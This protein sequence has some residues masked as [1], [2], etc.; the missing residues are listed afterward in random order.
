[1]AKSR[2]Y[3][4]YQR[5]IIGRYYDNREQIDSQ[6][7]AEL[8]TNLY[9]S[10]GKKRQKL[11]TTAA[12][13]MRRLKVPESRIGHVVETNDPAILA[14]VVNDLQAGRIGG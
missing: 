8:V 1:M 3:S 9:L 2:E 10:D 12:D 5:K 14:E 4:S 6:R 7:L 13:V 11:W